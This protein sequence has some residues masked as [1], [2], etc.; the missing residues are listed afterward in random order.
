MKKFKFNHYHFNGKHNYKHPLLKSLSEIV[1]KNLYLLYMVEEVKRAFT[2][3]PMISFRNSR[4]L[5]SY[6]VRAKVYP[7]ERVV[8]SFKCNK[9]R[10]LVFV[11]VTERNTFTSTVTGKT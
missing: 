4:K 6:L 3:G 7:T 9:P 8:W 5:S 2:P 10:C 11:N 1:S